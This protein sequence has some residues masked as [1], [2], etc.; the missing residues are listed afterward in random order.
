MDMWR[1]ILNL[2]LAAA[3]IAGCMTV[4]PAAAE[5]GFRTNM[6]GW[7]SCDSKT[8]E[9]TAQGFVS[10]DNENAL[11]MSDQTIDGST[12]FTYRTV[13]NTT[14]GGLAIFTDKENPTADWYVFQV[15]GGNTLAFHMTSTGN[16]WQQSGESVEQ[17][18]TYE[19]VLRGDGSGRFQFEVNGKVV[20]TIDQKTID[21][22]DIKG[23]LGL[24]TWCN[25]AWF[26]DINYSVSLL[27]KATDVKGTW[28]IFGTDYIKRTTW[29]DADMKG[30]VKFSPAP[31]GTKNFVY[32]MAAAV[33]GP[34][35]GLAFVTDAANYVSFETG[36]NDTYGAHI[37]NGSW[38]MIDGKSG[39]FTAGTDGIYTIRLEY[40]AAT[41]AL[42]M[43]VNG[44]LFHIYTGRQ[45]LNRNIG[46]FTNSGA[47]LTSI[48]SLFYKEGDDAIST[49]F[50]TNMTGW[51]SG[52]VGTWYISSA[53][54]V[55][56][57]QSGPSDSPG[58]LLAISD[59]ELDG[60]KSFTYEVT[61]SF[62]G[63][64][65]GIAFGAIDNKNFS[66]VEVNRDLAFYMFYRVGDPAA[67][68]VENEWNNYIGAEGNIEEASEYTIRFVYNADNQSAEIYLNGV[69]KMEMTKETHPAL[70]DKISGKV[71]IMAEDA[72]VTVTKAVCTVSEP[73]TPPV[74]TGDSSLFIGAAAGFL[75]LSAAAVLRKRRSAC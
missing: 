11:A 61:G 21:G 68:G 75:L 2:V 36:S 28:D 10:H 54:L 4:F 49:A 13:T 27:G 34:G 59:L 53:G 70:K 62:S 71:G 64:G 67:A 32:E 17:A 25:K 50:E 69:K 38:N 12:V 51:E 46:I 42:H 5:D 60:S 55:N 26:N 41:G 47:T 8:W 65:F 57:D 30:L 63:Y 74:E 29:D 58:R 45:F 6:T 23:S 14:D 44:S 19:M 73:Q 33:D 35:F 18:E 48:K 31:D 9:T 7:K 16:V 24:K 3:L 20:M 66:G 52:N 56:V 37:D 72:V 1:K 39:K 15:G 43:Y 40:Y 22:L